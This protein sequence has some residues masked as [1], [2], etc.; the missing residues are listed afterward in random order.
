ML[1]RS[2]LVDALFDNKRPTHAAVDRAHIVCFGVC[3]TLLDLEHCAL[4]LYTV[5]DACVVNRDV[6]L[7]DD[8][9]DLLRHNATG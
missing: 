3:L 9:D 7:G 5:E 4:A 6:L 2:R 1:S 8:L